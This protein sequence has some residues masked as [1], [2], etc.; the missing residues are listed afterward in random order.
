MGRILKWT[1]SICI[2][3]DLKLI[4]LRK[5]FNRTEKHECKKE[6]EK[7]DKVK[8]AYLAS[9]IYSSPSCHQFGILLSKTC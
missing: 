2:G 3:P 9:L 5:I 7:T 4:I 1:K 8:I 6:R